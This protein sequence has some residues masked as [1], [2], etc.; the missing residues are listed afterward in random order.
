MRSGKVAQEAA[1]H[2]GI[3]GSRVASMGNS[4]YFITTGFGK[5]SDRQVYVW[6]TKN[7]SAPLKELNVD[8]ASGM[9]I[10][11]F[12]P[13]TN[14][15]YLSG[16]AFIFFNCREMETFDTMSGSTMINHCIIFPST[17]LLIHF[18]ESVSY[19]SV[20]VPSMKPKSHVRSKFTPRWSSPFLSKCREK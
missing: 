7:L 3:K 18:E 10:P 1:G 11:H 5:T 9:L 14:M 19:L 2:V 6:D 12:D 20:R 16:K 8:T 13:D 15:L 17:S 4:P